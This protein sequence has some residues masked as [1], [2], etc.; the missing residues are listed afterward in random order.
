MTDMGAGLWSAIGILSS[1]VERMKTGRGGLVETSLFETALAYTCIQ[2]ASV[3]IAPRRMKPQ[4]SGADGIVP[5]QAFQASDG[6]IVIG[7]GNDALFAKLVNALG[8]PE[9]AS[10]P[11]FATNAERVA[12][13]HV[14]VALLEEEVANYTLAEMRGLLERAGVPNAPVQTLNEVLADEHAQALGIFQKGPEGA[15]QTV[16][17]P[18]RFD[19]VR[20]A[21]ERG[22][23]KLGEDGSITEL[24]NDAH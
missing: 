24:G 8:R 9:L 10:D 2:L 19:G 15:L 4:G 21:Y 3:T 1:L 17:L 7:G 13:Q 16:G 18:L 22:A 11:R 5:Y 23:P 6:W 14:I 12:H 20:P